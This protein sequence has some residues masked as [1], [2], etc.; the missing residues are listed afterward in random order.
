MNRTSEMRHARLTLSR[1]PDIPVGLTRRRVWVLAL[2]EVA[3]LRATMT[4][5]ADADPDPEWT[6]PPGDLQ[7][8]RECLER[9]LNTKALIQDLRP[10]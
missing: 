10:Y 2:N 4:V 6:A 1:F 3:L 9:A 8:L 7:T 5:S